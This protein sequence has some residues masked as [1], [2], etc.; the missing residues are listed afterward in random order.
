MPKNLLYA[1][2]TKEK[3]KR[4]PKCLACAL[5]DEKARRTLHSMLWKEAQNKPIGKEMRKQE[6]HQQQ[7]GV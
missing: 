4:Y 6:N 5:P 2:V 3:K 1:I 7:P